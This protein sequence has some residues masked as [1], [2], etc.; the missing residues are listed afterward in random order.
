M[1][2]SARLGPGLVHRILVDT[3]ADSNIMFRNAFDGLGFKNTNLKTH[4][5][6]VMGLGD[7][8][9]KPDG[10]IDLPM[11]IGSGKTRKTVMAEFV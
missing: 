2:I 9:I 5:P 3:G 8:F 11:T 10:S 1:V 4:Q 6:G 7:N